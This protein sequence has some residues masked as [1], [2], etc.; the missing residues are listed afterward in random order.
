[1]SRGCLIVSQR[2][3]IVNQPVSSL[4]DNGSR[5]CPPW[6]WFINSVSLACRDGR[7]SAARNVVTSERSAA[8]NDACDRARAAL[9]NG[10]V[11]AALRHYEYAQRLAPSNSEITLAIGAA[12]LHDLDPRS[13]EA[14]ALVAYR[15]DV[16]EAWIGLA[17][18]Y[19]TLGHHDLAA[20]SLGSLL[21]RHGHVRGTPT[22]RLHDLIARQNG[23]RGWCAL[24]AGGRLHVTLFEA[25]A[26]PNRVVILLD[27]APIGLRA[28]GCSREATL[29]R[30]SYCLP[31]A[32]RHA[33]HIAVCLQ[34]LHLFGSPLEASVIGQLEGFVGAL[35]GGLVGWA[36]F[37]HDPD[38]TPSV[39]V[40]GANGAI[41]RVVASDSASDVPHVQPFARP[42]RF[43]VPPAGLRALASPMTVRDAAGRNLYGSPLD[44]MLDQRSAAGTAEL[45]RRLFPASTRGAS[46]VVDLRMAAVPADI[47]GIRP[48][49]RRLLRSVGVDVVIPVYRGYEPTMAC[50][51]SVLASLPKDA[52]CIVVEDAS[53][54]ARLVEALTELAQRRRI[55]LLRQPE[56]RGFPATANAGIRAAAD[57]DV[58]LLNS[59]TLVPH[60]WVERLTEAAYSAPDIGSATPFSNDAT[61]FS[62]PREDGPNPIPDQAATNQLDR[63]ARR[64]NLNTVTDV[65]SAHGFCVYLRRD[66]L[67]SVGLL[68]EDLFAQGY[69]E[70]NDF[71]IRARHLGWRHVA[72]PGVFVG[73]VGA[74][75]FGGAKAQLLARNLGVLNRLHPGY[76]ALIATFR[77]DDPL[78]SARFAMDA[79][80]WRRGRSRKGAVVLVTHARSGGVKRRVAERCQEIAASGLRPIVLTPGAAAHGRAYC[81]LS[82]GSSETFPNLRFDLREGI[83]ELAAFLGDDKPVRLELHHFIGHDPSMLGLAHTLGVPYDVVVHD[84]AWVCPR[85][86]LV[87]PDKR[88]CGEPGGDACEACYSDAG[89]SL[90]EDIRPAALRQRSR[91]VLLNAQRVVVPSAD[92]ARR[93]ARYIPELSCKV[94]PWEPE[95]PMPAVVRVSRLRVRVVVVGAIGI[96]KGYE[97]LLACARHVVSQRMAMEFVVVGFTCDDKRLLETGVV[98]ITGAYDEAEAIALIREQEAEVGFL[99]ALW[100][101]TWSY[102]LSQMWQSGLDVVAFEIGAPADRIQQTG[103][104]SLLPLG[105]P[106]AAACRALLAHR[107]SSEAVPAEPSQRRVPAAVA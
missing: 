29:V 38:C 46:S 57:R 84:Y 100:P 4:I 103:R 14:F 15:D 48:V 94:T 88:Y 23:E 64:A 82:D 78:A 98:H 35:D 58:I 25:N 69:G 67:T 2:L 71:C 89:G 90:E 72:V 93:L 52:R 12:R 101:E 41:L 18:A 21:S 54:E 10:D 105:A 5:I 99:P 61:I 40:R 26:N 106:P 56:N 102:T 92:V 3:S 74:C 49:P 53:P 39:T 59:D 43:R 47:I 7:Q 55:V 20:H 77:Q 76:D 24:S 31:D 66:C 8:V 81:A 30:A 6:Q 37:P 42:R 22:I 62:Y 13:A 65:P 11:R 36:W 85:I 70:E 68:R 60:G 75:S 17:S 19:H 107:A 79:L 9:Q 33:R 73:H 51:K 97:Y 1:L 83:R 96:D 32:W 50:I 95:L 28:H 34:G 63:L 27:G 87:G 45:A 91:G 104:G 44:P 16:Q 86:T 80:H